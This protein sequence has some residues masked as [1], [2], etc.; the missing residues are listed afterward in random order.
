MRDTTRK[1]KF[2]IKDKTELN[3]NKHELSL[4]CYSHFYIIMIIWTVRTMNSSLQGL[5]SALEK[6]K[7]NPVDQVSFYSDKVNENQT[8]SEHDERGQ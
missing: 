5:L 7:S 4:T 3:H 6:P 1:Q 8:I 2:L